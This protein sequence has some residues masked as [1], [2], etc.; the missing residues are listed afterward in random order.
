M[1]SSVAKLEKIYLR[2]DIFKSYIEKT[3]IFPIVIKLKRITQ[4]DI[5]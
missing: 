1:Q 2:G 3:D 5:V 4:K